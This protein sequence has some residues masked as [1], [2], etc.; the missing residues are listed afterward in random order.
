MDSQEKEAI[1]SLCSGGA[2]F[3]AIIAGVYAD[4][5]GRKTGIY[6]GCVLFTIGALIQAASY[7]FA[8]MCVGR[9][10]VGFGVGSAAMIAPLYIAEI[11]PTKY[12]GRMIVSLARIAQSTN[13]MLTISGS[14]Q[15]EHHGW[16]SPF[17]RHRC[18][19]RIRSQWMAIHGWSWWCAIHHPRMSSSILPRIAPPADRQGP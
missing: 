7:T 13:H 12:R 5:F 18:R 6:I 16:T 15:H 1:T 2:F 4:R 10:V 8:Q 14:Q 17:L 3:G 11:A 9:L 19:F